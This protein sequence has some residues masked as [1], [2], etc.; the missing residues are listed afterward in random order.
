MLPE[1]GRLMN[2][3][4][5]S[6]LNFGCV[7][8]VYNWHVEIH[9]CMHAAATIAGRLDNQVQYTSSIPNFS[10]AMKQSRLNK[11]DC[12]MA[13]IR[14]RQTAMALPVFNVVTFFAY[15]N[16]CWSRNNLDSLDALL[17]KCMVQ[18]VPTCQ[19]LSDLTK[20][21]NLILQTHS[22]LEAVYMTLPFR[23]SH[24]ICFIDNKV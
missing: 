15:F 2:T 13:M 4:D 8:I 9:T 1:T 18:K 17:Y 14:R 10:A 6:Q 19:V 12:S 24:S 11:R 23:R 20:N 5:G 16:F 7:K 3:I 22:G 21:S